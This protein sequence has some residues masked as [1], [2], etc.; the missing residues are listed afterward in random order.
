MPI[1]T[2]IP[3][4]Q[5]RLGKRK[6]RS[7]MWE[8]YTDD[9]RIVDVE[10]DVLLGC[11]DDIKRGKG[12]LLDVNNQYTNE[13]GEW[14]QV[15]WDRSLMPLCMI[16]ETKILGVKNK[17]GAQDDD[18]YITKAVN[19]LFHESKEKTQESLWIKQAKNVILEKLTWFIAIPCITALIAFAMIWIKNR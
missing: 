8:M 2:S 11:C 10:I 15:G 19:Q 1:P 16:E 9:G 12:F 7:L 3:V 18:Q 14:V 13:R 17:P 5:I 4:P 6:E